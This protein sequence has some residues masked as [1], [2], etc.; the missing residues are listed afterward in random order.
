[1]SGIVPGSEKVL[2][3]VQKHMDNATFL[4]ISDMIS[5]TFVSGTVTYNMQEGGVD[6]ASYHE[7]DASIPDYMKWAVNRA[8]RGIL[9]GTIDVFGP[10]PT[11][12]YLPMSGSEAV[13]SEP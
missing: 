1:M 8:R 5:G 6:L 12:V 2:T 11:Y 7:A 13:P 4:L 9:E 10:C 3:S